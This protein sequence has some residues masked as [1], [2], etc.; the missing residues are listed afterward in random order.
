MA[1]SQKVKAPT[2]PEFSATVHEAVAAAKGN[3]LTGKAGSNAYALAE[4]TFVVGDAPHKVYATVGLCRYLPAEHAKTPIPAARAREAW[5]A[6]V[7]HP[8]E[9]EWWEQL[10]PAS[11]W[12]PLVRMN[13]ARAAAELFSVLPTMS[14]VE[15]A[16]H[17]EYRQDI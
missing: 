5:V 9:G 1:R 12:P 16:D 10:V 15:R 2:N 11:N 14:S 7:M 4:Q 3:V 17:I 13:A 8:A 6:V